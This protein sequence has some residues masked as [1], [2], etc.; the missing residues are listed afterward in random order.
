MTHHETLSRAHAEIS[1][2]KPTGTIGSA[3]RKIQTGPAPS[4]FPP[5][6]QKCPL[7]THHPS[8]YAFTSDTLSEK[9][10]LGKL[11]NLTTVEIGAF[12]ERS[13]DGFFT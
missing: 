12:S 11:I 8:V 7:P 5:S 4:P 13:G 10:E 1:G 2:L 6:H 9:H 3:G